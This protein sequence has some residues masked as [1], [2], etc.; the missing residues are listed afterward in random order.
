MNKYHCSG[1]TSVR[2]KLPLL[3]IQ[4]IPDGYKFLIKYLFNFEDITLLE[5][6]RF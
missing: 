5:L 4:L 2:M 3:K 1:L 6:N